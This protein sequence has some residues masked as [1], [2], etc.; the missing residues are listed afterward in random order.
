L[1]MAS[2]DWARYSALRQGWDQHAAFCSQL[3]KNIHSLPGISVL[4]EAHAGKAGIAAHD[5]TRLTI[6]VSGRG[7]TGFR[8]AELLEEKNVFVEM[9]DLKRVVCICTPSDAPGWYSMLFEALEKLP[10][11]MPALEGAAFV[12]R[13]H[14]TERKLSLAEAALGPQQLVEMETASGRIAAE[15]AGL[16]P[17]GIALWIPGE[18]IQQ[19]DIDLLLWQKE[20]GGALFGVRNGRVA[21]VE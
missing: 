13:F 9:A 10:Y 16:Y 6:D 17:P 4:N 5:P 1:L 8:A 15:A 20:Q 3:A 14:D 12:Q 18:V 2:L 19:Q 21:V 7:I 11:Q